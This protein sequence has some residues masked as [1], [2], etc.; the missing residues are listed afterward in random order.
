MPSTE[1]QQ[2]YREGTSLL[3]PTYRLW[4]TFQLPLAEAGEWT[5]LL[6][7]SIAI[8]GDVSA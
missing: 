2:T 5:L 6:P 8:A 4:Q 1:Q 7:V 3:E